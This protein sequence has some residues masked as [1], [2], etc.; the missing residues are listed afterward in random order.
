MK[1]YNYI[2]ILLLITFHPNLFAQTQEDPLKL[3]H[4]PDSL[5]VTIWNNG[6][7]GDNPLTGESGEVSWNGIDGI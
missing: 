2:L 4:T 7:F 3:V 5:N 6:I 1:R